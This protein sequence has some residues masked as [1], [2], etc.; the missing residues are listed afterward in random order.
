MNPYEKPDHYTKRAKEEGYFARSVYKLIEIQEK[1]GLIK[2]GHKILDLGCAPGS[3]SQYISQKIGTNG[4]VVGI[5]F[6]YVK[7]G[8]NNVKIIKG[9]FLKDHKKE[10]ILD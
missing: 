1:F 4:L 10:E 2:N 5:D 3:W 8:G 6:K 9:N 7:V